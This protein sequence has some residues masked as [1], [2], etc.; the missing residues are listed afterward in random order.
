M[1]QL[2]PKLLASLALLTLFFKRNNI[3]STGISTEP[4]TVGVASEAAFV[5][6]LLRSD[7]VTHDDVRNLSKT[8]FNTDLTSS[9]YCLRG[10]G[11]YGIVME[12]TNIGMVTDK[13][14]KLCDIVL[15]MVDTSIGTSFTLTVSVKDLNELLVPFFPKKVAF[16]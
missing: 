4:A 10:G 7:K 5:A 15:N 1:K 3:K 14:D 11:P 2:L 16:H 12:V 9:F 13:D 8:F 6:R